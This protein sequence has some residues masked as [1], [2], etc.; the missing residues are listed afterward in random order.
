MTPTKCKIN[1]APLLPTNRGRA[2]AWQRFR[3][4]N[5]K[6]VPPDN[7]R[8]LWHLLCTVTTSLAGARAAGAA[9]AAVAEVF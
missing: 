8:S 6:E 9:H 1:I 2:I 4:G 7:L 5:E 3:A